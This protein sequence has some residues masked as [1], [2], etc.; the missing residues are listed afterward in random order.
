MGNDKYHNNNTNLD[1][2]HVLTQLILITE[3]IR[4]V[5]LLVPLYR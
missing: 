1:T 2:F 5:L 3:L 4:L